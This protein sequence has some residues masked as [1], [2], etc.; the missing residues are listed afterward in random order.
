MKS[1]TKFNFETLAV[2]RVRFHGIALT[3]RSNLM[4]SSAKTRNGKGPVEVDGN[5]RYEEECLLG[6]PLRCPWEGLHDDGIGDR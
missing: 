4:I 3:C 2:E 5:C 1:R 6:Q